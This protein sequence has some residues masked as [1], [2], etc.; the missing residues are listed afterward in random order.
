MNIELGLAWLDV[1]WLNSL[2]WYIHKTTC[3]PP[4][5]C[6]FFRS[7]W[8]C[9]IERSRFC[10]W[11]TYRSH[12][13]KLSQD[14]TYYQITDTFPQFLDWTWQRKG[15]ILLNWTPV[16]FLNKKIFFAFLSARIF[17]CSF[18]LHEIYFGIP[19]PPPPP[20]PHHFFNGPSLTIPATVQTFCYRNTKWRRW[21]DTQTKS[22]TLYCFQFHLLPS[23]SLFSH[24]IFHR[25]THFQIA[26]RSTQQRR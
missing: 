10:Y 25:E 14:I 4:K 2:F 16:N 1:A 13:I 15:S 7:C 21:L 12:H 19:S 6:Q 23:I 11:T 22:S 20:L 3:G 5:T 26:L 24:Y 17:F 9:G 18:A 8:N